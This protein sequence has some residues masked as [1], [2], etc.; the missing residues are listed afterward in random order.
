RIFVETGTYVGDT[1]AA[2][3]PAFAECFTIEMSPE[4]Y[5]R[6]SARFSS[7]PLIHCMLGDSADVLPHIV[8]RLKEPA[9]FWLDAHASGGDTIDTG[10]GPILTELAA[11]HSGTLK[12]V[13]L[14]DDARGHNL[15]AIRDTLPDN[16]SV[17]LRNDIIRIIP[18]IV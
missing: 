7:S 11:I 14:I 3:A 10:K 5:A 2:L 8:G 17:T 15:M 4:L 18:R 12:H 13:T 16:F 9:L 1:T 6:A